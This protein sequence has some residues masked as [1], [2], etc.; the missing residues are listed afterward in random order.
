M[1][2]TTVQK[3]EKITTTQ[4]PHPLHYTIVIKTRFVLYRMHRIAPAIVDLRVACTFD[5]RTI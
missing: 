2:G 3:K 5:V 1:I 4:K